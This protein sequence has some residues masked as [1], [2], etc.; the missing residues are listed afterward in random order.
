MWY[1]EIGGDVSLQ[2]RHLARQGKLVGANLLCFRRKEQVVVAI[3]GRD[4]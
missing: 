2:A 3:V 4:P 1:V